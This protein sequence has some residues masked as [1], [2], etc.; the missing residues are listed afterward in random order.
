MLVKVGISSVSI[1][2]AR[3]N[4]QSEI[5]GW[6]FDEVKKNAE[7]LW[8]KELGKIVVEGGTQDQRTTFYTAL[9]HAMIAPNVFSDVDGS[10]RGMDGKIHTAD[11]FTMYTVFSLWD[12]FRAEHPLLTIIDQKRTLDFIKSFLAKYDQSGILPVW[13]LASNE[14]WCMI[15]Y[16]S[17]P[18]IVDAYA[19]GIKNFDAQKA[20]T[21][22][23]HSA[24][25]DHYGLQ[26]YRMS[27][28][29]PGEKE[30][31]S[32]SKTL[33]Y[34]YDDW[35]IARMASLLGHQNDYEDFSVRA[36]YF[37]NVFDPST[38]FMRPKING[39]WLTPFDPTSVTNHYTEA[40]AW[41]YTFFVPQDIDGMIDLYGGKDRFI[42]K[43]DSLFTVNPILTG[44]NQADIS[45]MIGE[46][47]Q[48]N[49]PSHHV[50]YL[51]DYAGAP[52][53]T[54][55]I[56]RHIMD[57]L[58]TSKPD[59][60]CGNDDCGQMSAWYVMSAIGLYQVT[61]GN[62]VYA[63]GSPLFDKI[64]IHEENGKQFIISTEHNSGERKYIQSATLNG[65]DFSSPFIEHETIMKG[66]RL[67]CVMTQG[68]NKD[69]GTA[70]P[71]ISPLLK[72][73]LIVPVPVIQSA[74]RTFRD[75]MLITLECPNP[76]AKIFY[77]LSTHPSSPMMIYDKPIMLKS[78]TTIETFAA[79]GSGIRS[80]K[81]SGEFIRTMPIG[82]I[83]L[84]TSYSPQYT[85]GGD[86]ALVDGIRG[87]EDFRLGAWQGYEGNNLDA[88]IDLGTSKTITDVAL[89]CLQ[90]IN[91]WI[92]FPTQVK[93]SFSENQTTWT[94]STVIKNDVSPKSETIERKGFG[95]AIQ[96]IQAR[97]IR[98]EGINVGICPPWHKGAGNKAWLFVDEI[99]VT[100]K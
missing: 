34:S 41:Q 88:V 91:S 76:H 73:T 28:F 85:G 78:S 44:R 86:S 89:G 77:S 32:V 39:G 99:T 74:G 8:E 84:R 26:Y 1:E 2:N 33:E 79:L 87:T 9:Y 3:K 46:Y 43:L 100:S 68:P 92:F 21:A 56:V 81:V 61:P 83:T 45:G 93:F 52:W 31:E 64:T 38:G 20:L 82:S 50:A 6:N 59:G 24:D 19:K 35:C 80:A 30:P 94:D 22:M 42:Q 29:I 7:N 53:K 16:H 60:L 49:E 98:I 14:T 65:H 27:G 54:Q 36:Q 48:G 13:E 58:Y 40:N 11:G 12:T 5:P 62:P 96:N 97:Y 70:R 69:W 63:I 15:G 90:D 67:S 51:Y 75:S 57:T 23:E 47:A 17:V 4:L 25:L 37:K 66:G 71:T 72:L 18:V 55:E 10:Y 95:K